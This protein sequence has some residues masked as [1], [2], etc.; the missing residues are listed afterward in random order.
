M[1]KRWLDTQ[2]STKD[3]GRL[4]GL[5]GCI[6]AMPFTV[7]A[8]SYNSLRSTLMAKPYQT[9]PQ[10]VV[11]K[12]SFDGTG[13]ENRLLSAARQS[14]TVTHDLHDPGRG[15][16]ALQANGICYFGQWSID[17]SSPLHWIAG[18]GDTSPRR[19]APL[20]GVV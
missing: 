3:W 14:L 6:M 4:V 17:R 11:N 10:Y 8:V 20:G 13:A 16:K 19:G 15:P 5:I 18:N 2:P 9:L 7:Q 12:E 1:D